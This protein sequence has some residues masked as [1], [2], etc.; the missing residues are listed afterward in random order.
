M[1]ALIY[2]PDR[3]AMQSGKAKTKIWILEFDR[4]T[5]RKIDP[6]TGWTGS[7][8]M[9]SQVKMRF[10]SAQDAERYATR[11]GISYK[12]IE[13][14]KPVRQSKSYSDNFS[15]DKRQSWTH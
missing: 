13:K 4:Q 8:D 2:Q 9:L 3:N 12:L 15:A 10:E 11:H 7:N 1:S 14:T 6:L 5:A